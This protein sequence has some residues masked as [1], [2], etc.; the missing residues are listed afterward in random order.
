MTTAIVGTAG[1]AGAA[2]AAAVAHVQPKAATPAAAAT[3]SPATAAEDSVTI[4]ATAQEVRQPTA[5]QVR[6]L[7]NEGQSVPQIATKLKI[8]A[9]EVQNYLGTAAAATK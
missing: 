7:R 3:T 9:S 5:A 1:S 6:L 4:S 8:S 2:A